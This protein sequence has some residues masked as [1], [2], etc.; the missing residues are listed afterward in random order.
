MFKTY[1]KKLISSYLIVFVFSI[2]FTGPSSAADDEMLKRMELIIK[3]QQKQIDSQARDIQKLMN[4]VEALKQKVEKDDKTITER[5]AATAPHDLVRT[6]SDKL[7]V[8]IY[9]QVNRAYMYTDDG[10]STENYIVDNDNISTRVGLLGK[11]K[12]N[13]DTSVGIRVELEYQQNPSDIVNQNDKHN[14]GGDNF[15]DRQIDIYVES[16]KYGKLSIG[17][18]DTASEESAEMDLSGTVSVAYSAIGDMAGGI[19]FYDNY[20]NSLSNTSI[21]D[22]FNNFDGLSRDDRIRYDTPVFLGFHL[23]GSLLSGNGGDIAL[24]YNTKLENFQISAAAAWSDPYNDQDLKDVDDQYSASASLLHSS[25]LNLSIAAS[26][27]DYD[28]SGRDDPNFFYAKLGFRKSFFKFGESRFSIEYVRSDDVEQDKDEA[29]LYGLQFVQDFTNLGTEYFLN[30]R[31]HDL[32]RPG[33][34]FE[35][36]DAVM[37]GIRVKF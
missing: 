36:I 14:V 18:G 12:V 7:D 19:L 23:S 34:D 17:K 27:R 3:Q 2:L 5:A 28:L 1:F 30:W 33:T 31:K 32:D 25:G 29:D 9:G 20:T 21:G 24:R 8:K 13:D 6:K 35:E 37:T 10:D 26:K 4:Q 11:A 15:D 16:K 22:V